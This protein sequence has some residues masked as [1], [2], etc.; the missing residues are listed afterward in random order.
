[1]IQNSEFRRSH[2]WA[3]PW[4][5]APQCGG[6]R[7]FEWAGVALSRSGDESASG[8]SIC[9]ELITPPLRKRADLGR[10]SQTQPSTFGL[11]VWAGNS[12]MSG[13]RASAVP[14]HRS[15]YYS[16]TASNLLLIL[17]CVHLAL[18]GSLLMHSGLTTG[19]TMLRRRLGFPHSR[20]PWGG[21]TLHW[22]VKDL[23]IN[24]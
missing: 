13:R 1:M 17:F 14:V 9:L 24:K 16:C 10:T 20:H 18:A 22:K 3:L 5:V 2:R 8:T 19:L 4:I 23:K 11:G 21:I 12:R 15:T 6:V 7:A